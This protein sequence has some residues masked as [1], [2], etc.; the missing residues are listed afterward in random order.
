MAW[1][2]IIR[3]CRAVFLASVAALS[4]GFV[5]IMMVMFGGPAWLDSSAATETVGASLMA[6]GGIGGGISAVF[7][8]LGQTGAR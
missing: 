5:L 8:R 6:G 7:L 2:R 4:V 1:E 3:V